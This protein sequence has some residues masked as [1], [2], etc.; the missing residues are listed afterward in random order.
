MAS[1]CRT[2]A[3][4]Y[5]LSRAVKLS[6]LESA[7]DSDRAALLIPLNEVF[8]DLPRVTLPDFFARLAHAGAPI[9]QKKI[10]TDFPLGTRVAL[11]DG[12]GFFALAEAAEADGESVLR[13][14]RLFKI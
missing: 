13:S 8:S 9:Y 4:G 5:P 12:D 14:L 3:A 1:L 11:Y 2:E 10:K 7:S 6:A